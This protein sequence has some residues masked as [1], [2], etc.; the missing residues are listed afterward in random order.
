MKQHDSF[1]QPCQECEQTI[2][3]VGYTCVKCGVHYCYTCSYY[4]RWKCPKCGQQLA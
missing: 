2:N 1:G 4:A 3:G